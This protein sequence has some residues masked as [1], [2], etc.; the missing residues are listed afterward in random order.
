MLDI[1]CNNTS[2]NV[3]ELFDDYF[4]CRCNLDNSAFPSCN[5]MTSSNETAFVPYDE[6]LKVYGADVP[7]WICCVAL[8]VT[9]IIFRVF[10]YIFLRLL[11]KPNSK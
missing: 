4:L 11:H 7:G 1:D 10:G 3:K 2:S 6:I 5:N 9:L 8:L